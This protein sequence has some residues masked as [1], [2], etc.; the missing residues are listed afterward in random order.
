MVNFTN[1][2]NLSTHNEMDPYNFNLVSM[3]YIFMHKVTEFQNMELFDVARLYL[4]SGIVS[5]MH[6]SSP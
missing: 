1:T 4:R 3:C 5:T 6:V 2:L